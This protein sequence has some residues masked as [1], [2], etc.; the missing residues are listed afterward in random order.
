MTKVRYEPWEDPES[1]SGL[2]A[3]TT[4]LEV[5]TNGAVPSS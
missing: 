1:T 3:S 4:D 2:R 5:L